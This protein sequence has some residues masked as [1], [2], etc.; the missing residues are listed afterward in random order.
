MGV[1]LDEDL[2]EKRGES[3]DSEGW[4]MIEN[5]ASFVIKPIMISPRKSYD[6]SG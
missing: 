3:N 2:C 4:K 5:R 6:F 1:I